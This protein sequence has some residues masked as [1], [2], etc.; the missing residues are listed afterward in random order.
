MWDNL[1]DKRV[2]SRYRKGTP[3]VNSIYG[4]NML[5]K[6]ATPEQT[7]ETNISSFTLDY[8]QYPAKYA[9]LKH[10]YRYIYNIYSLGI[11]LFKVGLWEKLKNYKDS[12]SGYNENS[13]YNKEDYYKRRQ[14]IYQ[15]YLNYLR[16]AYKDTYADV[17]L[18][19]II[20]NSSNDK[21]AKASKREL[22]ARIVADL[23]GY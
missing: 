5:G 2:K 14:Q 8:Y 4:R 16:Q 9:D 6:V 23:E 13:D 17:I 18:S 1:I 3:R 21:V 15:E 11:L 20:I 12:R 7:K 19:Y 22:Y 10:L